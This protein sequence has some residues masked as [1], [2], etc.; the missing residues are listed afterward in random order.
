M[1]RKLSRHS[2]MGEEAIESCKIEVNDGKLC[3]VPHVT[4]NV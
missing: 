2:E 3:K 1:R 4:G